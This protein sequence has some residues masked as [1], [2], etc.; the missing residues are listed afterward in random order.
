MREYKP[1]PTGIVRVDPYT[2]FP[3]V[4]NQFTDRQSQSGTLGIFIQFLKTPEHK[5]LFASG[6][7]IRCPSPRRQRLR[8]SSF[9]E[10]S[11]VNLTAFR[12]L[13]GVGQQV[14]HH[15]LHTLHIRHHPERFERSGKQELVFRRLPRKTNRRHHLAAQLHHVT[16][17]PSQRHPVG[18][19]T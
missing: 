17:L 18:L 19:Q 12:K 16:F 5:S 1:R 9:T 2:S 15:L 7:R 10:K 11:N 3:F 13:V 8:F 14:N 4:H 6:Y